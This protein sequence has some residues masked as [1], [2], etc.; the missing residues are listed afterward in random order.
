MFPRL[1]RNVNIAF[2]VSAVILVVV[3]I[4]VGLRS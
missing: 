4:L 1:R 3:F 2:I